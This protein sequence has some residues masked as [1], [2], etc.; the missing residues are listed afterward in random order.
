MRINDQEALLDAALAG[1]RLAALPTWQYLE[2]D[3]LATAGH[4]AA[5]ANGTAT[6]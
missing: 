6:D 3:I 5:S 4:V 1:A 2:R